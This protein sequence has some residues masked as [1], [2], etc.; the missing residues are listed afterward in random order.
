MMVKP[1][2]EYTSDMWD[3]HY[4]GD[5]MELEKVQRRAVCWVLNDYDRFSSVSSMLNQLSWPVLQSCCKLFRL[6]TLHNIFY[7]PLFLSIPPYYLSEI[8]SIRQYHPLHYILPCS[9]MTAHQ[10]SYFPRTI[11]DWNKLP[12]HFM[13]STDSDTFK[14]ELQSLL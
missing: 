4:V 9:S 2:L 14:T 5:I 1:Q 7:H 8:W 3:H 13:E 6:H 12:T 10:N 11:S